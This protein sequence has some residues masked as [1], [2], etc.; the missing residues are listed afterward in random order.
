MK[1]FLNIFKYFGIGLAAIILVTIG[2]DAADHYDNFS[3][4]LIGRLAG[5]EAAGSCPSDMVYVGTENGGF[6]LDKYESSA[7]KG[8]PYANPNNQ[9]ETRDNIDRADCRPVAENGLIPW[10]FLSQTQ[11]AAACA[12]AG[13]RLPTDEEWYLAS[14]GT[15]DPAGGWTAEDCQVNNNWP[16]QPGPA[17]TGQAC[18]SAAGAY[19]MV[20]NVWEWVKGEIVEGEIDSRKMPPQGYITAVDSHGRPLATDLNV[21][22]PNY[23]EDYLWIKEKEVRGLARGGYWG[24]QAQAGLYSFYLVF[25][26]SF[27]GSGVGFRCAK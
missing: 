27:A 1:L 9:S 11:A 26:P 19:D 18:V 25:P 3:Q 4:S 6:C 22:D 23:N 10:R 7:S 24:N 2:I 16:A 17:G 20:G 13:K 15:P 5:G 21:A 8:C 12:K 14:L